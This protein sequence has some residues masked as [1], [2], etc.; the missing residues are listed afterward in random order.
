MSVFNSEVYTN[1]YIYRPKEED[2]MVYCYIRVSTVEQNFDGQLYSIQNY[3]KFHNLVIDEIIEEKVSGKVS[4]ERRDLG[5]LVER[6]REGDIIITPE[7]SRFGRTVTDTLITLDLLKA[8]KCTV[9]LIKENQV[10]GTKEFDMICAVYAIVAQIE[11]ERISERT[12]EALA[13]RKAQGM[14][15]GHF[16]GYVCSHIKLTDYSDEIVKLLRNGKSISFIAKKYGVKWITA[17]NFIRDRLHWNLNDI[18]SC[19]KYRE[20]CIEKYKNM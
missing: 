9:H 18:E 2:K 19:R 3:A 8:K 6:V 12:K 20:Y 16:K 17:R 11:R 15:I 5:K 7:L 10:S 1:D 13:A 4:R 14:K